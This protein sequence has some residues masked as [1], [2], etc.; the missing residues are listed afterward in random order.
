NF[1]TD[2]GLLIG[3]G[4]PWFLIPSAAIALSFFSHLVSYGVTKPRL[5]K[6]LMKSLGVAGGW[7][8]VFRHGKARREEAAGLGAYAQLYREAAATKD[9]IMAQI[10]AGVTGAG[11]TGAVDVE[12]GPSLDQYVGQVRLLAQSANE[13]DRLVEAIPMTDLG[14]DKAA[15]VAK[16]ANASSESLKSE[17][18]KSIAEID[19]QE[20]S[21]QELKEQSEVIRLRLGSSVNQLK[22]TRLDLAR[23]QATPGT[24]GASA[25]DGLRKKTE[26]LSRYRE[27]LRSSYDETRK[28]PFAE[29]EELERQAE[30]R[31]KLVGPADGSSPGDE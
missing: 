25:L 8:N 16:E 19:K 31:K 15:L 11:S 30:E 26:E 28:D 2:P 9:A 5:E 22:Q 3:Q 4:F 20:K 12:L 29:L 13:I 21:Y 10:L 27:D 14:K 7:R 24:E 17:Y 23:L 18:K 6:K 1:L